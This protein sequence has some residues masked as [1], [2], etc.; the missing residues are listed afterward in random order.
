MTIFGLPLSMFLV[1]AG[2]VLAGSLGAIHYTVVHIIMGRPFEDQGRTRELRDP[3]GR[4]AS[5]PVDGDGSPRRGDD[6]V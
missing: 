2:T 6:H 4:T 3:G 5:R 1:F